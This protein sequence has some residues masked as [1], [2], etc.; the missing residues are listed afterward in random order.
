M[1]KFGL[2]LEVVDT[3]GESPVDLL[4]SGDIQVGAVPPEGIIKRIESE[5]SDIQIIAGNTGKLILDII[6][7][8]QFTKFSDLKGAVFGTINADGGTLYQFQEIAHRNGLGPDD[9]RVNRLGG[10][11]ARWKALQ[12]GTIDVALQPPPLNYMAED[13]GF[14][15][16]GHSYDFIPEYQYGIFAADMG[17]A[18]SNGDTLTAFLRGLMETAKF[19]YDPA[20]KDDVV[21]I[22]VNLIGLEKRYAERGWQ[23]F[24]DRRPLPLDLGVNMAGMRK[25]LEIMIHAG[26]LPSD[27]KIDPAKYIRGDFLANAQSF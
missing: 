3:H 22:A 7:R 6:A 25:V 9:Y 5:K 10:A 23:E 26:Q 13:A 21:S 12:A 11:P 18:Q 14:N 8:P 20:N 4:K 16:L 2:A 17:W 19:T 27:T 15:N 24:H 1:K